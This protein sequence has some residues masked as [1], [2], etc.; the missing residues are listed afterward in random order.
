MHDSVASEIYT[1]FPTRRSSD[2]GTYPGGSGGSFPSLAGTGSV[3]ASGITL[4]RKSTRLKSSHLSISYAVFWLKKIAPHFHFS[5]IAI[6][7][8]L[9][10]GAKRCG[11]DQ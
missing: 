6:R 9:T 11:G 1:L 10:C 5:P 2:L 8:S 4:D 7:P 3:G